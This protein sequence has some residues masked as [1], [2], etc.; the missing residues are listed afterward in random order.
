MPH[1]RRK[2]GDTGEELAARYLVARGYVVLSRNY[3]CA[4]GEIDLVCRD[5]ETLVFVEVKTR[6]GAAFGIPEE[7]VTA[8]K[9]AR[10][11]AA[12]QHYLQ[13]Q[14]TEADWRIDVVA[15]ELDSSGKLLDIRLIAGAEAG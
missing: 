3:R 7:A 2:L 14:S 11:A 9:L 1:A 8:R 5:G 10:L 6:R 12:G 4:A 15:V 13:Q